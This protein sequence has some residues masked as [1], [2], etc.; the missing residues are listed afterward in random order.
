MSI[1]VTLLAF[2]Y[3]LDG[4]HNILGPFASS[5]KYVL[6]VGGQLWGRFPVILVDALYKIVF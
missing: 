5:S 2:I 4:I 6:R 3:V 1:P